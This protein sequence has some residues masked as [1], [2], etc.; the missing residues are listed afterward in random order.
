M[1]KTKIVCTLGPATDTPEIMR[2]LILSGMN[3]AR[4]NFS[5]GNYEEHRRRLDMLREIS[6]EVG[7]PVASLMDTKGPEIRLGK[8]K[9]KKATLTK[10][11]LFI[12]TTEDVMGDEK[13]VS[14][15]FKGLHEDL[16]PGD[17]VLLDDGLIE[18]NVQSIDG[19]NIICRVVNGGEISDNKGVNVPDIALSMP[20]ISPKDR[21]D[22]I[23]AIQNDFDFI[24][25]SFVRTGEDIAEIGRAHV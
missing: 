7:I 3:V 11:S 22:L 16:H 20:Y 6:E 15:S 4:F 12:L 18:L 13:S 8:F 5:H 1:R 21:E 9:D 23:F 2:E 25:A 24:A 19:G 17:R 10:G 14:I